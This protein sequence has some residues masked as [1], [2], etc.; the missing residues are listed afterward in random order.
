MSRP[1]VYL[2]PGLLCDHTVWTHQADAL[3]EDYEIRIPE[4][5]DF[6]SLQAMAWAILQA[7]PE[8]F[9]VVGH[10]MGG[11]V[12]F[13]IMRLDP[14]RVL[15]LVLLDTGVHPVTAEE[16]AKRQRLLDLADASGMAAV[17]QQWIPPMV[18]PDRVHDHS[19]IEPISQM[20]QRHSV[21]Q[22]KGQIK[23]LLDR[24][25]AQPLLAEI[26]CPT[27]VA[28]G[29]QDAWS[30]LQQHQAIAARIKNAEL[31][32]IEDSGHMVSMEQPEAL[33]SL[34][35]RWLNE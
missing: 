34:L 18:H 2:I 21:A 31:A 1:V 3:S 20:V 10:S 30:T 25:D 19:L 4:L 9:H 11:R 5:K 17:A 22:F 16:P 15:S 24:R 29:R 7:A 35:R 28:C 23:A 13:E 26:H 6:D 27:L 32:I 12:A 8:K 14:A 33:T